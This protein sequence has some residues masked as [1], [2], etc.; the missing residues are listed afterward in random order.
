MEFN[1]WLQ[2]STLNQLYDRTVLAYPKTTKRQHSTQPIKI[3]GVTL[4]PY[5]GM[6]TLYIKSLAQ[7]EQKEYNS[8]ILFKGVNY[9][10]KGKLIKASDGFDYFIKDLSTENTEVLV[11]CSC[12]DF[13]WRGN[14]ANFLNKSLYSAKRKPYIGQG[15]WEVNPNNDPILCKHLIKLAETLRNSKILD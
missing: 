14:Y 8:Q 11:R 5:V 4:V 9:Q 7:N 3:S 1:Q 10:D 12:G 6:K 15:L 13:F 2:E